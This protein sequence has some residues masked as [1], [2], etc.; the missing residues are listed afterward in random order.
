MIRKI[1]HIGIAVNS[2][3]DA[4]KLYTDALGLKVKDIEIMEAQKVRIALIPVGESKIE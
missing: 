3:E 2:I 1:D 4:V